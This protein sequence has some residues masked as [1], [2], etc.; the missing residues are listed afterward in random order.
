MQVFSY[1]SAGQ[2]QVP[3]TD[4]LLLLCRSLVTCEQQKL[5]PGTPSNYGSGKR[6]LP[7]PT[8]M[9]SAEVAPGLGYVESLR[10]G[11]FWAGKGMRAVPSGPFSTHTA[12]LGF[13]F[14]TQRDMAISSEVL[15][16]V[17]RAFQHPAPHSSTQLCH[18]PSL[19]LRLVVSLRQPNP[20]GGKFP[21]LDPAEFLQ[22]AKLC[23]ETKLVKIYIHGVHLTQSV[24]GESHA[25]V[26][27]QGQDPTHTG[28]IREHF[29]LLNRC[30]ITTISTFLDSPQ[31]VVKMMVLVQF[32]TVLFGFQVCSA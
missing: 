27:T 18:I 1:Y 23:T 8:N 10:V 29:Q 9:C 21:H 5:S 6:L 31:C 20:K 30:S 26:R 32:Y 13:P 15:S 16:F 3:H 19:L 12:F 17:H 11:N 25:A 2:T 24:Y 28:S 4:E 7:A 14:K 22:E